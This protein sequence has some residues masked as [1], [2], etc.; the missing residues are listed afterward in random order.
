M[1]KSVKVIFGIIICIVIIMIAFFSYKAISKNEMIH[2]KKALV[3]KDESQYGNSY[4]SFKRGEY[5]ENP[6]R[7][8]FKQENTINEF[9]VFDKNDSEYEHLLKVIEDRMYYAANEDFNLWCFTPYVL[10][11]IS[12]SNENFIVFDYDEDIE[13]KDYTYENDFNRDIFFRFSNSTRL[14]RLLDYLICLKESV[15][16]DELKEI[17][18]KDDFIPK[19]QIVSGYRYMNPSLYWD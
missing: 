12:N 14:Y 9:Y 4:Q 2:K 11:D 13:N 16:M 1:K 5:K 3:E 19:D 17:I 6:D 18:G 10:E 8:V 7:I 15:K